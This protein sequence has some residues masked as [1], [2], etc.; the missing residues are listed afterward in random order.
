M[1]HSLNTLVGT[2]TSFPP[3]NHFC[4]YKVNSK[5][6][7][8]GI[9]NDEIVLFFGNASKSRGESRGYS[10]RKPQFSYT[11]VT[12]KRPFCRPTRDIIR[13]LHLIKQY[14][15]ATQTFSCAFPNVA[16]FTFC[17]G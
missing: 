5:F 17:N 14:R 9:I 10:S 3:E 11:S 2:G 6:H 1:C 15:Y 7:F 13:L 12:G 16:F 4:L 8:R